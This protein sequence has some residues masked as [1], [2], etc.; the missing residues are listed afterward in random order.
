MSLSVVIII[1]YAPKYDL[2]VPVPTLEY[3]RQSKLRRI[4]CLVKEL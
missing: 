1:H 4:Q 3:I 2:E